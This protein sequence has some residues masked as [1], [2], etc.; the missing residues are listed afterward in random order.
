MSFSNLISSTSRFSLVVI[1]LILAGG[2]FPDMVRKKKS[3]NDWFK[4]ESITYESKDKKL[5]LTLRGLIRNS[6]LKSV[7]MIEE[8]DSKEV[9]LGEKH[10][11]FSSA[12]ISFSVPLDVSENSNWIRKI[13]VTGK[14][15]RVELDNDTGIHMELRTDIF[16]SENEK[17]VLRANLR[18]DA[19]GEVIRLDGRHWKVS[20]EWNTN[21]QALLQYIPKDTFPLFWEEMVSIHIYKIRSSDPERIYSLLEQAKKKDCPSV[22][23]KRESEEGEKEIRYS[24]D[25]SGCGKQQPMTEVARLFRGEYGIYNIRYDKKGKVSESERERWFSVLEKLPGR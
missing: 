11:P 17:K 14:W 9:P 22:S 18:I 4:I 7:R 1:L 12:K 19:E 2:C 13:G 20:S 3:E 6:N 10:G 5:F 23:W 15:I 21:E 24:W 16:I 8:E 25:H